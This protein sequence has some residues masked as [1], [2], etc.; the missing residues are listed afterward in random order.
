[1]INSCGDHVKHWSAGV[2]LIDIVDRDR[3]RDRNIDIWQYD[4]DICVYKRLKAK[5]NLH[6][7]TEMCIK[8][9]EIFWH[10]QDTAVRTQALCPLSALVTWCKS[11][12]CLQLFC[13]LCFSGVSL[14][15]NYFGKSSNK[16]LSWLFLSFWCI[17][18]KR[19]RLPTEQF[20]RGHVGG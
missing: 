2:D 13:T 4:I 18:L 7:E 15:R 17:T 14:I 1:M 3:D 5:I 16:Y 12:E 8:A 10:I 20:Y 11:R 9:S 19:Q 6:L